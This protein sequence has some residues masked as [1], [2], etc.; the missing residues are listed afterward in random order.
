MKDNSPLTIPIT[1]QPFVWANSESG[2]A[3]WPV[4]EHEFT[5]RLPEYQTAGAAGMDICA[6]NVE[7]ITLEPGERTLVPCGFSLAIPSG[8]EGQIRPRSGLANS[9]GV[10]V[11]NA[12][13]TIDSDYRGE[14]QVLLINHGPEPFEIKGGMRIEHLVVAPVTQVVLNEVETLPDT[15]R[16]E[17]GFGHTGMSVDDYQEQYN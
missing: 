16:G 10:T 4:Q 17:G 9:Y 11:L 3:D 8:Y 12:P 13:G 1:K 15:D 2:K 7:V 14:V 5:M 6:A